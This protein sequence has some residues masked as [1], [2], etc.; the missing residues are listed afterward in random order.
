MFQCPLCRQVSNL[1]ASV[2]CEDESETF[3]E[4]N[5]FIDSDTGVEPTL[6]GIQITN[7]RHDESLFNEPFSP[8]TL[9]SQG[10]MMSNSPLPEEQNEELSQVL[11]QLKLTV[12]RLSQQNVS[13][14]ALLSQIRMCFRDLATS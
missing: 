11:N 2:V 6:N 12:Q 1:E 13:T 8:N 4:D 7:R 14:D 3:S 5:V 10:H 9:I